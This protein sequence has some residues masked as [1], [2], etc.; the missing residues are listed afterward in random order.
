MALD[1]ATT[2]SLAERRD[3]S[4][5]MVYLAKQWGLR[6]FGVT[7]TILEYWIFR[8]RTS[9]VSVGLDVDLTITLSIKGSTTF[10]GIFSRRCEI[11]AA[12]D[13]ALAETLYRAVPSWSQYVL[14][15]THSLQKEYPD[16]PELF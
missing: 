10:F 4:S 8:H 7:T 5:Y 12:T 9:E 16:W 2:A 15:G 3:D 14:E 11:D 6:P 1:G 13:L